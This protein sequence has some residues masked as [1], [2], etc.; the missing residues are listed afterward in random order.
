MCLLCELKLFQFSQI[1]IFQYKNFQRVD[2]FLPLL[3]GHPHQPYCECVIQLL[4][5]HKHHREEGERQMV[6][7]RS[8]KD[9]LK[10]LRV[11]RANLCQRIQD[12]TRGYLWQH[13]EKPL[14]YYHEH[15]VPNWFEKNTI[16]CKGCMANFE[17][18][19]YYDAGYLAIVQ[20]T[21]P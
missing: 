12:I 14:L 16:P 15:P 1:D 21:R 19:I 11:W 2:E 4:S 3:K 18:Q 6:A 10:N 7:I 20:V 9:G 13:H 8:T 17:T 5:P